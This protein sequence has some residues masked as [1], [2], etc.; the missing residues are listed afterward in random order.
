MGVVGWGEA[1]EESLLWPRGAPWAG[2]GARMKAG[3][4]G[5]SHR[6]N[7]REPKMPVA[8]GHQGP[9]AGEGQ[10]PS[11]GGRRH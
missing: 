2:Q 10:A 7:A 4:R 11:T 5:Q 8:R 9:L 6:G 3:V 1:R